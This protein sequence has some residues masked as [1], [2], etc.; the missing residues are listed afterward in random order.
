MRLRPSRSL[1]PGKGLET[2][3]GYFVLADITP[4]YLKDI[5]R[6]LMECQ[7]Q[8]TETKE[9]LVDLHL[10]IGKSMGH[11]RLDS[12][13]HAAISRSPRATTH[14]A[15]WDLRTLPRPCRPH[16]GQP[17]PPAAYANDTCGT[18]RPDKSHRSTVT[19]PPIHPS[20]W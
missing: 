3:W 11:P 6:N 7:L 10:N 1:A 9:L 16:S 13:L 19:I 4:L 18:R 8:P 5:H 15:G 12:T 20:K 17:H 2:L 14:F